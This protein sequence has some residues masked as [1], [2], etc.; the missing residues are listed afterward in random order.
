[1]NLD[2]LLDR[3]GI[4][5]SAKFGAELPEGVTFRNVTEDPKVLGRVHFDVMRGGVKL[6]SGAYKPKRQSVWV[7]WTRAV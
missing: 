2:G 6:G 1:M 5:Y 7:D 3:V 4:A